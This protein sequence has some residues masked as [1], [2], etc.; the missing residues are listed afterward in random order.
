QLYQIND[1][2]VQL[3]IEKANSVEF[4]QMSKAQ[5]PWGSEPSEP[6]ETP[7]QSEDP[8]AGNVIL[9]GK[10]VLSPVRGKDINTLAK[11]DNIKVLIDEKTQKAINIASKLEAYQDGQMKSIVAEVESY[12]KQGDDHLIYASIAPYI[13]VKILEEENVKVSSVS[14]AMAAAEENISKTGKLVILALVALV[15]FA[16]IYFLAP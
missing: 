6:E 13:L 8:Y 10:V 12:Q 9:K 16:V 11:G 2:S 5:I 1:V 15:I 7:T 3:E 4:E 14:S